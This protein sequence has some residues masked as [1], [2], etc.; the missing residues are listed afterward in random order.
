MRNNTIFPL[1]DCI[2]V[3]KKAKKKKMGCMNLK[4][5]QKSPKI[6]NS[7]VNTKFCEQYDWIS[8]YQSNQPVKEP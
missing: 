2:S 4:E 6:I 3:A 1:L 5:T 8:F 7:R